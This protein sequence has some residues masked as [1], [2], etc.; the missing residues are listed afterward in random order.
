MSADKNVTEKNAITGA[1]LKYV[2][3]F[4]ILLLSTLLKVVVIAKAQGSDVC[5][6]EDDESKGVFSRILLRSM[7]ERKRRK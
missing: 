1:V 2:K 7:Q 4:C 6:A 3:K 5:K